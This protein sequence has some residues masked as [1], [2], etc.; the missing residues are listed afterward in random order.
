[1]A[2]RQM[3]IAQLRNLPQYRGLTVE[4]LEEVRTKVIE[5]DTSHKVN[6]VLEDFEQNYDLSDMTANDMLDLRNLAQYYVYLDTLNTKIDAALLDDTPTDVDRLIR[7]TEKIQGTVGNLQTSLAITRKQ[8]KSDKEQDIVSAWEDLKIRAKKFLDD[9]V[10][11]IYCPECRML[12][13]NVWFLYPDEGRNAL[14]LKC[15]RILDADSDE[16]CNHEFT[17]TSKELKEKDNR[18]IEGVLQT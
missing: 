9:R 14:R 13:A 3:T 18:N 15:N 1:M 10:S 5:G 2:K 7:I 17:V 12:L 8:R 11:Y 6:K 16:V 4:E